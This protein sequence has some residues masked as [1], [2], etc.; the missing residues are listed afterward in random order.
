MLKKNVGILSTP[1]NQSNAININNLTW[2]RE[3]FTVDVS[4][5][6]CNFTGDIES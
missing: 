2:H 6:I 3:T 4:H 5:D 1:E